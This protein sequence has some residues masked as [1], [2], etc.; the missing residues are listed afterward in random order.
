MCGCALLIPIC[1]SLR[2]LHLLLFCFVNNNYFPWNSHAFIIEPNTKRPTIKYEN[3]EFI[4]VCVYNSVGSGWPSLTNWIHRT[5]IEKNCLWIIEN[6]NGNS[7]MVSFWWGDNS[8]C[9]FRSFFHLFFP[10]FLS[11]LV[12]LISLYFTLLYVKI[13]RVRHHAPCEK[14]M[15][16]Y[17]Y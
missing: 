15:A 2:R 8:F 11:I 3:K 14:Q 6:K 4:I 17:N 7:E 5:E 10:F 1:L 9:V 13:D 16:K 12:I